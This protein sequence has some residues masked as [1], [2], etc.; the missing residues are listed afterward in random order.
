MHF[1]DYLTILLINMAAGMWVLAAFLL[2][3][4]EGENRKAW[5]PALAVPG[6]I[7]LAMGLHMVYTWPIPKLEKANLLWANIAFG[8]PTVLLGALFLA[9]AW[10]VAKGW[11]LWPIGIYSAVAG[12]IAIV[13]GAAFLQLNLTQQPAMTAT[14]F[15]L[16][17]LAG[18]LAGP[19]ISEMRA[20]KPF[21]YA[22]AAL[23]FL[24]GA[25]WAFTGAMAY[26]MHLVG[27]SKV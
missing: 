21:A 26:W 12:A 14:G 20:R 5:A 13:M 18:L 22:A 24:A 7:A 2:F 25:L 17:G 15:I 9:A 16:S 23:L 3:R 27:Y 4:G 19:A 11:K 8:E 6:I 10:A 1:H